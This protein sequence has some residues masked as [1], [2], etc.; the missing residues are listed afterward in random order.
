M[1]EARESSSANDEGADM[2]ISSF[3][4]SNRSRIILGALVILALILVYRFKIRGIPVESCKVTMG[5]VVSEIMG[6]GTLEAR[7]QTTVSAK[8]QGR[9]TELAVD[10]NDHVKKGQL[11]AVLD[12]VELR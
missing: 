4:Q 10:Q 1:L 12:E 8:I 5:T 9:I 11:M 3:F 2:N 6:T 7:Y